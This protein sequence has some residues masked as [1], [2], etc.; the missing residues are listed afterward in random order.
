MKA[1]I[2]KR[3]SKLRLIKGNC[4]G[5]KRGCCFTNLPYCKLA[6]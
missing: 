1:K 3:K 6:A 4:G 5:K 2:K